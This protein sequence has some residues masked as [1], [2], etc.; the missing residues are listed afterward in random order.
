MTSSPEREGSGC[1]I[2]TWMRKQT[3]P[4]SRQKR[5]NVNRMS[6]SAISRPASLFQIGG[7]PHHG[8]GVGGQLLVGSRSLHQVCRLWS[9]LWTNCSHSHQEIQVCLQQKTSLKYV[10]LSHIEHY[11]SAS[12]DRFMFQVCKHFFIQT[13]HLFFLRTFISNIS[14]LV[15]MG[16]IIQIGV[17]SS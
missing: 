1:P 6:K 15:L 9:C 4:N 17:I 3:S 11:D 13:D 16:K 14:S 10:D 2:T 12:L 8:G 5:P 7:G